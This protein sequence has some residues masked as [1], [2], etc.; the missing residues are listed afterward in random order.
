MQPKLPGQS[1]ENINA[2][3]HQLHKFLIAVKTGLEFVQKQ[4][5]TVRETLQTRKNYSSKYQLHCCTMPVSWDNEQELLSNKRS[6]KHTQN[7]MQELLDELDLIE[8]F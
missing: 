1:K 5:N 6:A 3:L 7:S 4:L 8:R 2:L